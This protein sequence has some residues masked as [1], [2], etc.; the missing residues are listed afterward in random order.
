MQVTVM[1]GCNNRDVLKLVDQVLATIAAN[2]PEIVIKEVEPDAPSS[3]WARRRGGPVGIPENQRMEIVKD[4]FKVQG[5]IRAVDYAQSRGI[6][7]ATLRRW[8]RTLVDGGK[9]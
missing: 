5:R 3:A 6:S 1:R 2:H 9:L 8:T 4:W 7:P